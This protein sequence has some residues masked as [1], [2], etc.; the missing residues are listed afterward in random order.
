[1]KA[2][3]VECYCGCIQLWKPRCSHPACGRKMPNP[4]INFNWT[5]RRGPFGYRNHLLENILKGE[6]YADGS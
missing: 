5:P 3:A 4:R 6:I 2:F 1:M